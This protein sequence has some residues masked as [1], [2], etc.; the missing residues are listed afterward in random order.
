MHFH[1][2]LVAFTLI[3]A[4]HLFWGIFVV[5]AGENR[6]IRRSMHKC[7]VPDCRGSHR[8]HA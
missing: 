3:C 1:D 6:R 4:G 5:D 8:S 2:T 7:G